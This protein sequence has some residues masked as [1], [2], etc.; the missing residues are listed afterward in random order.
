VLKIGNRYIV[1]P[2]SLFR[3]L[4]WPALEDGQTMYHEAKSG[5]VGSWTITSEDLAKSRR[6]RFTRFFV[7]LMQG[8]PKVTDISA[9]KAPPSPEAPPSQR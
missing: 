3:R 4:R 9:S 1:G 5:R 8:D 6:R 7:T 2:A